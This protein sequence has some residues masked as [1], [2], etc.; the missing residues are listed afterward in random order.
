VI[1]D[2]TPAATADSDVQTALVPVAERA[3]LA[4]ASTKTEEHLKALATKHQAITVVKDRAGREQAHNAAMELL[5]ARTAIEKV[6]KMARDDANKF[7]KAVIA[8]EDRL[9]AIT[10]AEEKRLF[11]VRDAW[12]AEQERIRKEKAEAEERRVAAIRQRIEDISSAP[13]NVAG[14]SATEI[15]VE[16]H[17][18]EAI[19]VDE[20]FEE[21][22]PHAA[23]AV[24]ASLAKLRE[25]YD[26][27][28]IQAEAAAKLAAERAELDRIRA[29][30]EV[31]LAAQRAIDEANAKSKREA[32]ERE[33][34]LRQ[35]EDAFAAEKAAAQA[36]LDKQEQDLAEE[37]RKIAAQVAEQQRKEAAEKAEKEA[38]ERRARED[39]ALDFAS[40]VVAVVAEAFEID[41]EE[42]EQYITRAAA[43]IAADN[44]VAA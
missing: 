42:A 16:I 34:F 10:A 8:E 22:Q 38:E 19:V 44:K 15:A 2:L 27:A 6:S 29:D 14:K 39:A 4:L 32:A 5:K 21:F 35:Q 40:R 25:L 24:A 30:A 12:D 43:T 1:E 17:R 36:L 20:S 33:T 41:P 23:N 26:A 28:V 37:R 18:V 9:I 11:A 13:L 3:A 7:S 31:A